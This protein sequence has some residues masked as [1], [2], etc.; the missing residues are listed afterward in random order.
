MAERLSVLLGS[1]VA[2]APTTIGPEAEAVVADAGPGDVVMLENTR[3]QDAE[4]AND[5]DFSAALA[6]LGD[7]Y[8][9]DAFGTAHRAHA[10]TE[11]VARLMPERAAG[12]LMDRELKTLR[13]LTNAPETPFVAVVGGAAAYEAG[14]LTGAGLGLESITGL[15]LR[16]WIGLGTVFAALLLMT[17]SYRIVE[18]V[19]AGCVAIM[20]LVFVVTAIL[21]A[22]ALSELAAGAFVP[23]L[24][25]GGELTAIALIGTTIVPYNLF[26]HAAVVSERFAGIGEL[27]AAR[28]DL[29]VAIGL[30]GIVSA[31]VVVTASAAIAGGEVSSASDMA[32]QLEP[33]L[34]A[35]AGHAFALGYAAAGI[36]SAVTAP[37]AATYVVLDM[38][39]H[40]R[41]TRS[42][43]ARTVWAGCLLVG[44]GAALLGTKP[45]A[46]IYVAQIVNGMILPIVAIVLL[47]AV[48]DRS[49]LGEHVNGWRGNAAGIIVVLLCAALGVRSIL[50]ALGI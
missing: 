42:L 3:F 17:G 33:L 11:G 19:L 20:G 7:V 13:R 9:N 18:R 15:P 45:V 43:P 12:Y 6:R 26:L 25:D 35:W 8:V 50:K 4:T 10:S 31:A 14:N 40:D 22:P 5:P 48:N 49:R 37:L 46:L 29:V 32:L 44:A 2:V 28:R 47:T 21:V 1:P 36:S 30:G 34:G 27:R 38:L 41:D 24:P 16:I 23:R 39:S